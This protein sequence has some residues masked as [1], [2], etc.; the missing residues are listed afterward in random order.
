M[1]RIKK[2][3]S[4]ETI[5][6]FIFL[7]GMIW[8]GYAQ[9]FYHTHLQLIDDFQWQSW[10][11]RLSLGQIPYR[12]FSIP[13]GP[14]LLYVFF[15][16]YQ[17]FGGDFL[18]WNI[19]RYLFLPIIC[20]FLA[21]LISKKV[22][23]TTIARVCFLM[24]AAT[25]D[26]WGLFFLQPWEFRTWLGTAMILPVF[27]KKRKQYL[28]FLAGLYLSFLYFSSVEQGVYVGGTLV[29]LGIIKLFT[30]LQVI[31]NANFRKKLTLFIGGFI[32]SLG[33]GLFLILITGGLDRYLYLNRTFPRWFFL[34]L[35]L[36]F[37]TSP[38]IN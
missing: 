18:A 9:V 2:H 37:P 38:L 20:F 7:L 11:Y 29:V 30:N 26:L 10:L 28:F 23:K 33:F 27:S 21:I 17:L 5:I 6:Y 36:F 4:W 24:V 35:D 14:L 1:Q 12:D 3:I 8:R 25:Y 19:I 32:F 16:F 15:P 13:Y 31:R 22:Y 34:I